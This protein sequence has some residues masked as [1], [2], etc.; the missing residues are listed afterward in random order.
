MRRIILTLLLSV[1]VAV[2]LGGVA[3]ATSSGSPLTQARLE[4]S[5]T[6]SFAN[7]YAQQAAILGHE[8]VTAASAAP[9]AMCDKGPGVTQ[10]GPGTSW[11][12]LMSWSDPN[13]PMPSTGYGKFEITLHSNGC[14]TVGSPSTLVG[15]QTITDRR[16]RTV[17]NPAYEFD[18]CLDPKSPDTPTGVSFPSAVAITTTTATPAAD[19]TLSDGL[20]CGVGRGGCV[21]TITA[22]ATT[23]SGDVPIGEGSFRMSEQATRN[24]PI[25]GTLPAGATRVTY[26]VDT[27]TGVA[28]SP[29]TVPVAR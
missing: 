16:G 28:P 20:A 11:N 9:K 21:G 17:S 8:G 4:R 22:V 7:V 19:G 14:Y 24:V 10:S 6:A 29:L 25:S 5:V 13:V 18:A 1:L 15:Y 2:G 26:T 3:V 12:C 27:T 23:P